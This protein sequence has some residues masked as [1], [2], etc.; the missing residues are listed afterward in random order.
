MN[1]MNNERSFLFQVVLRATLL[2]IALNLLFAILNPLLA[3]GSVSIY[4]T[5]VPGRQRLPFGE[6]PAQ[7]YNLS[8]NNLDAMFASHIIAGTPKAEDEFRVVLIGDSSVWGFLS[9]KSR[10]AQRTDS[11]NWVW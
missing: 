6:N 5:L 11:M 4:N 9:R 2:F 10:H 3:L 1:S 7:A 8:L